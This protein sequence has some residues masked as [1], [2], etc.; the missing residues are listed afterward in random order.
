MKTINIVGIIL[1]ALVINA[2]K[3]FD[4][5]QVDPNRANETH[6]SLLLTGIEVEAFRNI[7]LGS[8][9]AS[10]MLVYTDGASEEQYYSWLRS[11]FDRYNSLRQIVKMDE[12]ANRLKLENYNALALF[13]KSFQ[14]IELTK[15]FGDVPYSEALQASSSILA[16]KYDTQQD[17][18]IRVLDDLK[19]AN[20]MLDPVKGEITGDV[21]F[22]GDI[23]KWKKLI[24][25][26]SLRILMSLSLKTGNNTLDVVDRFNEIVNN[27]DQYPILTSNDDNAALVFHDI[28]TNRYPFFNSNALKTAYYMEESF[29]NLLKVNNDPRLFIFAD[30][31]PLGEGLPD[32]D[33]SAY[34]GLD[35][36]AP[37]AENTN[38]VVDGQASR[39]DNR[40]YNDPVNEP[41][42]ALSYAEVEFTLAEAA[43]LRWINDDPEI[44]Y[45]NGILASMDFYGIEKEDQDNYL[46]QPGV[47][48]ANENA[49]ELII[50]QKYINYF[51]NGG[52]ESFYN[53]LR[54][55][56]PEF[57]VDGG[58]V[59]NNEEVPKRWMYP[60]EELQLNTA[61]VEAAI[62]RQYP[63]G[64]N[65]NGEMWLLK[66]E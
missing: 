51:M 15:A 50:T 1:L 39:I 5:L 64:D 45:K 62:S 9:M 28:A 41:S 59:L 58:G 56:F 57:S 6:P 25:S 34:G 30:K 23:L 60:Q 40:F 65:I 10:R 46:L 12:E 27:A 66:N 4:E 17:I 37:L 18:Y 43:Q 55:G 44:H 47:V 8:A 48:F 24:N 13:F 33:F 35:G 7:S 16:P 54:T 63:D 21:I 42:M 32:N 20:A 31:M 49:I 3:D 38:R 2:C 14:I 11:T 22:N 36:S 53:H 29:V 19:T 26:F 52:W 61:N